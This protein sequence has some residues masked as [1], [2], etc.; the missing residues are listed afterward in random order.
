MKIP[1]FVRGIGIN[2]A[3]EA[4]SS[5]FSKIYE[6]FKEED[7][8]KK[9][10]QYAVESNGEK[11]LEEIAQEHGL[12]D[13]LANYSNN[14]LNNLR[15]NWT[16]VR[17]LTDYLRGIT[18]E[19]SASATFYAGIQR[20]YTLL[21]DVLSYIPG[22]STFAKKAVYISD[23]VRGY[24]EQIGNITKQLEKFLELTEDLDKERIKLFYVA[25]TKTA[26]WLFSEVKKQKG[27]PHFGLENII[28]LLQPTS[29]KLGEI[30]ETKMKLYHALFESE[31]PIYGGD[32]GHLVYATV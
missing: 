24:F 16:Y 30:K 4:A 8:A 10:R 21:N 17:D 6:H 26:N 20:A 11:P 1:K 7:L 19:A 3:L 27:I 15:K 18:Q 5:I 12:E 31:R 32:L 22:I 13:K 25:S 29:A 2:I 23:T 14:A 28:R 9:I